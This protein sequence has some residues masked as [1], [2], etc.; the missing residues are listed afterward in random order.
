[1]ANIRIFIGLVAMGATGTVTAL[2]WDG[3]LPTKPVGDPLG[4]TPRTTEAPFAL[5]T[6][7]MVPMPGKRIFGRAFSDNVCGNIG[8][9]RGEFMIPLFVPMPTVN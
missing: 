8:G 7:E 2:P 9:G 5:Y 3:A 4:W 1:M 6:G